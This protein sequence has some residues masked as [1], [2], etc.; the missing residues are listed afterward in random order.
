L[1]ITNTAFPNAATQS[2]GC[3]AVV[4]GGIIGLAGLAD[5]IGPTGL[6]G[7][8]ELFGWAIVCIA[9]SILLASILRLGSRKRSF[10]PFGL[11]LYIALAF[12]FAWAMNYLGLTAPMW[13]KTAFTTSLQW[14]AAISL[15]A[16]LIALGYTCVRRAGYRRAS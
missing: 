13:A 10:R 3:L 7:F 2:L 12:A 11:L 14:I 1:R 16:F 6:R 9:A 15:P 5:G 8:A 4:P